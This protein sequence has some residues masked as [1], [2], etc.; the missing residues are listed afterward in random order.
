MRDKHFVGM[1][2]CL[3]LQ[4]GIFQNKNR[5]LIHFEASA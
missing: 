3:T 1:K 2:L 4:F 5:P